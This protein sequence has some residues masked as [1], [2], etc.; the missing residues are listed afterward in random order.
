MNVDGPFGRRIPEYLEDVDDHYNTTYR[1]A[2]KIH[3]LM[4]LDGDAATND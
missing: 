2:G 1:G 4:R 3:I